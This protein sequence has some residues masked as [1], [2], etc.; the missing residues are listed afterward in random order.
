MLQAECNVAQR[1]LM[2]PPL[3]FQDTRERGL[4]LLNL[5][6][7]AC[8]FALDP[9]LAASFQLVGNHARKFLEPWLGQKQDCTRMHSCPP[10]SHRFIHLPARQVLPNF[11]I[12]WG[13]R[14]GKRGGLGAGLD[15]AG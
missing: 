9:Y 1:D 6:R 11:A 4:P 14:I 7:Q 3:A 2:L 15:V 13:H 12:P 10:A 8:V 5:E